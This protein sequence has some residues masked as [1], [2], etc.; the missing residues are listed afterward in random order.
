M[1]YQA[2]TPQCELAAAAKLSLDNQMRL[3]VGRWT[4]SLNTLRVYNSI[5]CYKGMG[6]RLE[7][8]Q[9]QNR[10]GQAWIGAWVQGFW[11]GRS[12][13]KGLLREE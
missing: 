12:D 1:D 4:P 9:L 8:R 3:M 11:E 5:K 13:V 6:R 2:F 7:E 10:E